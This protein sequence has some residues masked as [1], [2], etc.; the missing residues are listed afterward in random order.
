MIEFACHTWSFPD[1]TLTEALGTIAR[2]GF[3]RVDIGGGQGLNL[4]EAARKPRAVAAEVLADLALYNL[5]LSDLFLMLPRIS[6]ADEERRTKEIETFKALLPFAAA[7]GAPGI[8]ISPGVAHNLAED[9]AALDRTTDS[10]RAMIAAARDA[11]LALSFAPHVDSM[12]ATPDAARTL[13][14]AV[15]G[16]SLTLDWASLI[17]AGAR[18]EEIT[19]LVRRS[20]HMQVRSAAKGQLQTTLERSKIDLPRLIEGLLLAGYEGT[21]TISLI[22]S[23]GQHRVAKINP[24]S[25]AAALRDALREA[26][27]AAFG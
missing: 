7:L 9:P 8:T 4:T 13:L 21:V 1:L 5:T 16:L 10:L 23:A 22:Q 11:R 6:V 27:D 19:S 15:D 2:L 3:R 25:E 18:H 14:D 20:R 24:V 17:Y 12:A 26:R